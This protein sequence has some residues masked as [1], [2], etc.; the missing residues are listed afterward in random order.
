MEKSLV[1][2]TTPDGRDDFQPSLLISTIPSRCMSET[3][4][5]NVDSEIGSLE[6]MGSDVEISG[7]NNGSGDS[8][9]AAP[10]CADWRS[11]KWVTST[12]WIANR[13][14]SLAWK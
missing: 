13:G 9:C 11:V 1:N 3:A 2:V 14:Q 6:L 5:W 8:P 12:L 10:K 7:L 4:N